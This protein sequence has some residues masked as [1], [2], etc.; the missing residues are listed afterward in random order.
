MVIAAPFLKRIQNQYPHLQVLVTE[1]TV[2]Q[3]RLT[4]KLFEILQS[5]STP[6]LSTQ[7]YARINRPFL[8]T[9]IIPRMHHIVEIQDQRIEGVELAREKGGRPTRREYFR[10]CKYDVNYQQVTDTMASGGK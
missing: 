7:K 4:S 9:A 10:D 3:T 6:P 5:S 2:P 8:S 1:L